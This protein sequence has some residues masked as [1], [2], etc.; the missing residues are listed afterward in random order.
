MNHWKKHAYNA[1]DKYRL[2]ILNLPPTKADVEKNRLYRRRYTSARLASRLCSSLMGKLAG[3]QYDLQTVTHPSRWKQSRGPT[4]R[5]IARIEK[6]LLDFEEW[7]RRKRG[8]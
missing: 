4:D 5:G 6:Y 2:P 3:E 1:A 7:S 8:E